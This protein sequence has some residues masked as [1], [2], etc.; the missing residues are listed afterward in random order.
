[1]ACD[2]RSRGN[3]GNDDDVDMRTTHGWSSAF[4]R[5]A[6]ARWCRF[7]AVPRLGQRLESQLSRPD[8]C[9]SVM[10]RP[11]IVSTMT[12]STHHAREAQACRNPASERPDIRQPEG[13][14]DHREPGAQY[15]VTG[16][17]RDVRGLSTPCRSSGGAE[18]DVTHWSI[19]DVRCSV[20]RGRRHRCSDRACLGGAHRRC[21]L[22]L[23]RRDAWRMPRPRL[24]LRRASGRARAAGRPWS[25]PRWVLR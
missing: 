4:K 2:S 12:Y 17:V 15:E 5:A 3:S 18:P 20:S 24:P 7:W 6:D 23:R 11:F 9:A 8:S 13:V 10:R 19:A 1:V 21:R 14:S 25:A 16:G 22:P